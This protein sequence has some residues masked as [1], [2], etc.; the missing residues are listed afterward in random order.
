ML[1]VN[2]PRSNGQKSREDRRLSTKQ[3]KT[4]AYVL[5]AHLE[6]I[7]IRP[8]DYASETA[9]NGFGQPERTTLR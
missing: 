4:N 9:S 8:P 3:I 2:E 5:A 1:I 7:A 6:P